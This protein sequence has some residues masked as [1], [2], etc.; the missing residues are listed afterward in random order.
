MYDLLGSVDSDVNRPSSGDRYSFCLRSFRLR[1]GSLPA[2][3]N[4]EIEWVAEENIYGRRNF[5]VQ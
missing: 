1:R 5:S 3:L 4:I 2:R